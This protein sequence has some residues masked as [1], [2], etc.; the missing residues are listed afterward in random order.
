MSDE[1]NELNELELSEQNESNESV[2]AVETTEEIKSDEP[3]E[4]TDDG[5]GV[6]AKA[7]KVKEISV[8]TGNAAVKVKVFVAVWAALSIIGLLWF[9]RPEVSVIEKRDLADF[10]KFSVAEMMDGRYFTKLDK[11][12]SD[13]FPIREQLISLNYRVEDLYGINGEYIYGDI[14]RG[15]DIPTGT[16]DLIDLIDP[17]ETGAFVPSVPPVYNM[18]EPPQTDGPDDPAQTEKPTPSTD[19]PDV[20]EPPRTEAPAQTEKPAPDVTE[21]PQTLP[22]VTDPPV[23]NPPKADPDG[24]E[25]V[26]DASPEVSGVILLSGNAA[27]DLYYFNQSPSAQYCLAVNRLAE[28]LD[29]KAQVYSIMIPSA[30]SVMLGMDKWLSIGT[31]DP[32]AA[33]NWMHS[34]MSPNVRKVNIY[35]TLCAHKNEYLFFRTD[36]HWTARGA[37]YAYTDFCKA[38]GIAAKPLSSY[39]KVSFNGFLGTHY[40]NSGQSPKLLEDR[41]DAYY[42]AATNSMVYYVRNN[43]GEYEMRNWSIIADVSTWNKNSLYSCFSGADQAYSY[44]HNPTKNDGS[45]VL[46]MKNSFGNAFLPFL[47]DHYEHI[48]WI[49]IRYFEDFSANQG[50]W[51]SSVS[52]LVEDKQIDDVISIINVSAT[53]AQNLVTAMDRIYK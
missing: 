46:L 44:A 17:A 14:D 27:Y 38:K 45:A 2:E 39:E 13:T 51:N 25:T 26:T 50:L 12:F 10:P 40:A 3:T 28:K 5:D 8:K 11:W 31:A 35:D 36:H 9:M 6:D 43:S 29:G 37:Y 22:T 30:G 1:Q 48:Y 21:P 4:K 41:V 34:Q 42:P 20:T 15:D 47:V 7:D 23:T 32:N 19:T 52:G 53:G 24:S 18:T 49:D 16:V 33:I